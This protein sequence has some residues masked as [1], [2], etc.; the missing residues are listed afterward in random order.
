MP[1]LLAVAAGKD[2]RETILVA[3][4]EAQGVVCSTGLAVDE[5]LLFAEGVVSQ[6]RKKTQDLPRWLSWKISL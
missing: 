6:E 1:S 2:Y 5:K 3:V 4:D